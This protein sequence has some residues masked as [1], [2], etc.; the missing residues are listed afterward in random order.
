MSRVNGIGKAKQA[1]PN[2]TCSEIGKELQ[3]K[4]DVKAWSGRPSRKA[5]RGCIVAELVLH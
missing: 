3:L 1:K 4:C 5:G 2:K